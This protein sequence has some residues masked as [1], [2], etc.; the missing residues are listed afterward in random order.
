MLVLLYVE[1]VQINNNEFNWK[2]LSNFFVDK[3]KICEFV[4]KTEIFSWKKLSWQDTQQVQ[5][6]CKSLH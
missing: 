2:K 4:N 3:Q 5:T 1:A 6:Q